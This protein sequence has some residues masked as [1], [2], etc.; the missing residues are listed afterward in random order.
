VKRAAVSLA[1]QQGAAGAS[2]HAGAVGH[3]EAPL[4]VLALFCVYVVIWFLQLGVR[5]EA[6]GKLRVELLI[7]IALI[8][9]LIM[10]RPAMPAR[11]P[12]TAR[13]VK[14]AT[15]WLLAMMLIQVPLSFNVQLSWT[16][17][18]DRVVKFGFMSVFI[19]MFVRSP[20]DL[21]WF[22]A[23][24]LLA[25]GFITQESFRG[26]LSGAM[27]WENQGVPRLHGDTPMF[28]HPNS[29]AGLAT[30][31]LPFIIYLLP[32]KNRLWVRA[33]LLGIAA[34]ALGCVMYSGSRTS[35]VGVTA[36][37]LFYLVTS[38]Y[39]I[40]V[41]AVLAVLLPLT[42]VNLPDIYRARFE[43]IFTGQEIEGNSMGSRKEIMRDATAVFEAHPFGVGVA[44]FPAVRKQMFGRQQDTHNLYLEVATNLGIQGLIVFLGFVIVML[45]T[46]WRVKQRSDHELA[47]LRGLA[48]DGAP[49]P[50]RVAGGTRRRAGPQLAGEAR[51][52]EEDLLLIRAAALAAS[53]YIY[54]RMVLGLFGMDLYEIYWWIGVGMT[55]SLCTILASAASHVDALVDALAAARSRAAEDRPSGA[56]S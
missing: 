56:T 23:A 9:A 30:G 13:G 16:I 38:P 26:A 19:A 1:V 15:G 7:G 5:I 36:F 33:A 10:R 32:L 55:V 43:T 53:G 25:C 52:V 48:A 31:V 28:R 22:L 37:V 46:L 18:V 3:D 34:T 24:F 45:R 14:I 41:I 6:L 50:P 49:A 20:R 35:Y 21:R 44:A 11:Y 51:A 47:R 39:K 4:A 54:I 27:V 12:V 40:R 8:A 42:W 17:F 29:L 2:R